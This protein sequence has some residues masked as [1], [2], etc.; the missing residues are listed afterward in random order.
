MPTRLLA[1]LV[2]A[3]LVGLPKACGQV[4]PPSPA[5][6]AEP[7]ALRTWSDSTGTFRITAEFLGLDGAIVRLRK[8]DGSEIRVPLASLSAA[9]Q[10][11]A[12]QAASRPVA[13]PPA[14]PFAGPV[15]SG[16]PAPAV[17]TAATGGGN[18]SDLVDR[19]ERAVVRIRTDNGLG[20][21]FVVDPKG[22]ICTNYHVI[23][24][25]SQATVSFKDER[26]L[27]VLGY[28]ALNRGKDLAIL[29]VQ[30]GPPLPSL[31][32]SAS[33]PGKLALV[34]AFGSPEGFSF[35]ATQGNVSAVRQGEEVRRI[36]LEVAHLDLCQSLG[37]DMD[38][39]WIQSTA[40]I[41]HGSS[42]GPLVDAQGDVVGINTWYWP[43][44][45]SLYFAVAAKE[46]ANLLPQAGFPH[47]LSSLP[48][49]LHSV[50]RRAAPDTVPR[51]RTVPEASVSVPAFRITLP[52][53]DLLTSD[54]M[55][56]DRFR[57]QNWIA[58]ASNRGAVN[59]HRPDGSLCAICDNKKGVLDGA[60]I[61]VHP[62]NS[63]A[64][65]G[66][67]ADGLRHGFVKTWSAEG[68]VEYWCQYVKGKKHGFCCSFKD[69]DL[70]LVLQYDHGKNTGV[71]LISGT[72]IRKSFDDE[73]A[74][75][76]DEAAG[77]GLEDLRET[78]NQLLKN[79]QKVKKQVKDEDQKL[80]H[81]RANSLNVEKRN[82]I[83]SRAIQHAKEA[84]AILNSMHK[85]AGL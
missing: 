76:A 56:V 63:L 55:T 23:D 33:L 77:P 62:S 30:A 22:L 51:T 71:H 24:G 49:S 21:G 74:A 65:Y 46:I 64:T 41:S 17:P 34:M 15:V 4:N 66:T 2:L 82:G 69:A 19:I 5:G 29:S 73:T 70:Q 37:Y 44:G 13:I 6:A 60:T 3:L 81:Q 50:A 7:T 14:N 54:L 45:Q 67:Y 53:G 38:S 11:Y 42:G 27:P 16:A 78:E 48:P 18:A 28:A 31:N 25:A 61:T 40:P 58:T 26:S 35:S 1:V 85:S 52:S 9:D 8:T 10:A 72:A 57:L 83:T 59:L 36:T 20:S 75:A 43:G 12:R 68:K 32:L 79:E 84:E 39:T 47:P 80:R